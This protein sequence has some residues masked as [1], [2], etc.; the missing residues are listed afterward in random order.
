MK[1]P[2]AP[3]TAGYTQAP[4]PEKAE[5]QL[6]GGRAWRRKTKEGASSLV[7]VSWVLSASAY[8]F[9]W[10][11]FRLQTERGVSVYQMD[12][13]LEGASLV[14][15]DCYFIGEPALTGK[16]GDIYTVGATLEVI[17]PIYDPAMDA[18]VIDG[19]IAYGDGLAA[20]FDR[21]AIFA[22]EDLPETLGAE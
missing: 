15:V 21:L 14:D 7:E 18:S 6:E 19:Y 8:E 17:R 22:N 9:F 5:V 11:F 10:S 1:F 12:L 16:N 4:G 20:I 3:Q 2:I 13:I